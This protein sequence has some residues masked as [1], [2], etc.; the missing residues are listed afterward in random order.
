MAGATAFTIRA[1]RLEEVPAVAELT[2]RAFAAGPYGHLPVSAERRALVDAVAERAADGA[3]L[4]AVEDGPGSSVG[5]ADASGGRL[6]G[7]V[8]LVRAGSPQSRLAVGDE[9]EL[10]LLAVA[11]EA[12]GSGLGEALALAAQEEALTWGASAVVLDTG[13]LNHTSQRLYERLGYERFTPTASGTTTDAAASAPADS[14]APTDGAPSNARPPA[15]SEDQIDHIDYRL[16]LRDRDDLVIRLVRDDEVDAV[17]AL[18][19]RAYE[20]AY[21][22]SD[23]YRASIADVAPRALEHQVWV[24]AD[25]ASG[26][27]LGSVATPRRGST[28][29]PLAQPGELDFR[30]LAVDPPARGR[31]VGEELTRLAIELARLRGLDRV[32]MNSGPQMTGAHRLYAKLGFDRLHEREREIVD[33]DRRFRLLAFTIDVPHALRVPRSAD[34]TTAA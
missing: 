5:R 9:A 16:P 4:V 25:A 15:A 34:E 8:S 33:G 3:V 21:E 23:E 1:A 29:S 28:I 12:R 11:P 30:L 10:R 26:E 17:A 32:V 31:G 19:V 20:Y 18:S 13:T 7:T 2:H 22:L 24:A 14:A 27:L 6:L